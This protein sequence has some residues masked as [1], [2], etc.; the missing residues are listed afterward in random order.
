VRGWLGVTPLL[1]SVVGLLA[2]PQILQDD[3]AAPGLVSDAGVGSCG[4]CVGGAGGSSPDASTSGGPS[5][6]DP[7]DG[8]MPRPSPRPP[9][10]PPPTPP[11][12]DAS[13]EADPGLG[14]D[15]WV[16]ALNG[17]T[18]DAADNCLDIQG[19]NEV[20]VDTTTTPATAV[21]RTYEGGSICMRGTIEPG[22]WG[23]VYNLTFADEALWDGASRGVR[24]FRIAASGAAVPPQIEVIYTATSDF[25]RLVAPTADTRIPFASTHPNC[26]ATPG[27]AAPNAAS[28]KFLRLHI[29]AETSAYAIDFCMQI[30][31]IP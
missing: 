22:G 24:G 5:A 25:C 11:T 14:P 13:P 27:A 2:C 17:P 19:W 29:P 6:P 21:T 26:T 31:A 23:A 10:T 7:P 16:V 8:P 12:S 28:L 4:V 30:R 3:F 1:A 9:P 20:V 15:C 18:H